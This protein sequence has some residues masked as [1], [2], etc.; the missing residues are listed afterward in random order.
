MMTLRMT[1]PL[2]K[3]KIEL[4][5]IVIQSHELVRV[6]RESDQAP[7]R[8]FEFAK[9]PTADTEAY[10]CVRIVDPGLVITDF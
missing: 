3:K 6:V 7:C 4:L 2:M 9:S 8:T 5:L 10:S 1:H